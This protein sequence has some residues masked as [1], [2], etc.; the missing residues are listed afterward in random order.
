[1][2]RPG[3]PP[4]APPAP[5]G[6][7]VARPNAEPR[8]FDVRPPAAI[9]GAPDLA[10]SSS[11]FENLTAGLAPV[12]V[13][14][15]AS[16]LR[17]F[18]V[19]PPARRGPFIGASL[20][21]SRV[22]DATTARRGSTFVSTAPSPRV[23]AAF[24]LTGRGPFSV[25]VGDGLPRSPSFAFDTAL[26]AARSPPLIYAQL[27]VLGTQAR[28]VWV[29]AFVMQRSNSSWHFSNEYHDHARDRRT[30]RYFKAKP[31]LNAAVIFTQTL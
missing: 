17:T 7:R 14:E 24:P 21:P 8:A 6:R 3:F 20:S 13:V 1:V 9:R 23:C 25:L 29:E 27:F 5:L 11:T 2:P 16:S 18:D 10:P 12:L 26:G 22:R 19:L 28:N 31:W 30:F 4:R 15:S